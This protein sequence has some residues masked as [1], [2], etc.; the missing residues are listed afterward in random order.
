MTEPL[1][2]FAFGDK[3]PMAN[4]LAALVAKG[5]KTGTCWAAVH[6]DQ[7]AAVGRQFIVTDGRDRDVAIIETVELTQR[8]FDQIDDEWALAEGEGDGSLE[9]WRKEHEAFFQREGVFAPNMLL[10]CE[11]F[12]LVKLLTPGKAP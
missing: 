10:W 3:A 6:G 7:E 1:E 9:A 2:R 12:K 4:E 11:R 5:A 8:R